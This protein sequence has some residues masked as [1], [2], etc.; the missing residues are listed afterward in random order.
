MKV[1]YHEYT[2]SPVLQ[3]FVESYWIHRFESDASSAFPLQKCVPLGLVNIIIHIQQQ[4]FFVLSGNNWKRLP[5]AFFAGVYNEPVTWKASGPGTCFGISL[6]PETVLKL[7]KA[8]VASLFNQYTELDN[9]FGKNIQNLAERLYYNDD[10]RM[11]V[12]IAEEF[13]KNQLRDLEAERNYLYQAMQ[14]IRN[15]K[16]SISIEQLSKNLYVSERQLQ[17]SFKETLGATPKTYTRIIRFR[18]AYER[19]QTARAASLSWTDV[20][21]DFGYSDQ[22]HLIRDF[23]EFM[24]SKPTCLI[25]DLNGQEYFQFREVDFI[26][27]N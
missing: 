18:N 20:T 14:M 11:L 25:N 26:H 6:K 17:R 19:V 7:F 23:K 5:D 4:D 24:G 27:A 22:A 2:P 16:G 8:P 15:S 13:F 10:D 1:S 3:P 12:Q 9:F 21:Y